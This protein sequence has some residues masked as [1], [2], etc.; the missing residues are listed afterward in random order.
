MIRAVRAAITMLARTPIPG[1]VKTRLARDTSDRFAAEAHEALSLDV[2]ESLEAFVAA[3]GAGEAM[4]RLALDGEGPARDAFEA[5]AR[6]AAPGL[7]VVG[8]AEGDLGARMETALASAR[9][10]GASRCVVV[11]SDCL[12]VAS[13]LPFALDALRDADAALVPARDGGFVLLG[14]SVDLPAGLLIGLP[15]GTDRALESTLRALRS[16]G[17]VVA[18]GPRPLADVDDLADWRE[19][20]GR[21]GE[22]AALGRRTLALREAAARPDP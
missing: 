5:R 8:Q 20:A 1:R 11:G 14:A 6:Q 12:D 3:G 13:A 22:G 15:W 9:L 19:L 4:L 17:L 21:L 16:A 18:V 10:A 2:L 7:V